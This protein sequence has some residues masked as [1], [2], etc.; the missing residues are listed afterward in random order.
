MSKLAFPCMLAHKYEEKHCPLPALVEPK[1]DGVRALVIVDP[2]ERTAQTYSRAGNAFTSVRR[3]ENALL[4][5]VLKAGYRTRICFDGELTCGTFKQTVSAIKRQHEEA[6]GAKLML[7]DMLDRWPALNSFPVARDVEH[8]GTLVTR[9]TKLRIF[10]DFVRRHG[11]EHC[12][13]LTEQHVAGSHAAIAK[14]YASFRERGYEGAIVKDAHALWSPKRSRAYL[15]MK[16]RDTVD[17]YVCDALEGEGR[18]KGTLGALVCA[19]CATC[20]GAGAYAVDYDEE[21]NCED[22]AALGK[23]STVNVGSGIPDAER[24]ELWNMH[25]RGELVGRVAEVSFHERTPDGSLRHP[26]YE[27][28]RLDK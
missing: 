9:R 17:L 22:C 3:I 27:G 18:L 25:Q 8:F 16:E 13:Q 11:N 21:P 7:F 24:A 2:R 15:K 12:L 20:G 5:T 28:L 23:P 6:E 14:L 26:V 1:L 19:L 10:Y 4:V